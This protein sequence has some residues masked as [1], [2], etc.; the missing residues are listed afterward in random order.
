MMDLRDAE[1]ETNKHMLVENSLKVNY[2]TIGQNFI[3]SK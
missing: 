3:Y 1:I 2:T